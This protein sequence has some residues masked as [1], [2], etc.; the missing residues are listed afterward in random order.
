M[1]LLDRFKSVFESNR[2]DVSARFELDRQ[3][4]TG[5][6]SKFRVAREIQ[7]GKTVGLK[8]LDLEKTQ[9]FEARFKGLKKPAEGEIG[10]KLEHPLIV[11]TY[12]YGLTTTNQPYILMEYIHGSGLNT[13]IQD[14][15]PLLDGNRV[16]LIREMA[17]AIGAV[18]KAGFIHR[19][20]CPRNFIVAEDGKSLK[21]IDFGL[22]V[23]NQPEFR[24]PGNRTGT[25]LY[26]APEIVRRRDTDHRVD[27][28]ALGVTA[29]R[30][31]TFEH[32]W[33]SGQDTSGKAALAHDTFVA[34]DIFDYNPKLNKTLGKAITKCYESDR[35]DRPQDIETFLRM[36]RSVKTEQ[37]A[38]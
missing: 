34:K 27:I 9:T 33:S 38:G 24:Q 4:S 7:T 18:H 22:T 26:T 6:M 25:P 31:C 14:R 10:L 21:L 19:D 17:E 28:F 2:L 32:P 30:L 1:G 11:Q 15:S 29:Y 13:L 36:I 8:L 37:E 16:Q 12:E 35:D 23:P 5:T 3:S 20:I